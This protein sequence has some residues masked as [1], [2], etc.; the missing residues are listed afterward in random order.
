MCGFRYTDSQP[1]HYEQ[2]LTKGASIHDVCRIFGF[3]DPL[4]PV[5]KFT[6]HPLL[7]LLTMSAF[8]GTP[9]PTQCGR[10]KW[11]P[12]ER[13][14]IVVEVSIKTAEAFEI[15]CPD[16]RQKG[17]NREKWYSLERLQ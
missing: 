11:K 17:E 6:Q 3:F 12:P 1:A 10:H 4:P 8:E 16:L 5:R 7:R 9:L 15:P 14:A 2:Y 13:K